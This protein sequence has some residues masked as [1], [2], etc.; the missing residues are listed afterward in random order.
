MR[1]HYSLIPRRNHVRDIYVI[2][3]AQLV[4]NV[5][6]TLIYRREWQLALRDLEQAEIHRSRWNESLIDEYVD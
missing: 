2:D 6:P 1:F 5:I 4:E 3:F